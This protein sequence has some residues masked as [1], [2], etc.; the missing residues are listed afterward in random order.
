MN[1][2]AAWMKAHP[3]VNALAFERNSDKSFGFGTWEEVCGFCLASHYFEGDPPEVCKFCRAPLRDTHV[4]SGLSEVANR[5]YDFGWLFRA[6]IRSQRKLLFVV[7]KNLPE[8][9]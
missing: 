4:I 9:A 7:R 5:I 6:P 1:T 3:S 2:I 8:K